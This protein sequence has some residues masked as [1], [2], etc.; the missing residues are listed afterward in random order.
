MESKAKFTWEIETTHPEKYKDLIEGLSGIT[1][2]ELGYSV[3]ELGLVREIKLNEEGAY[4]RMLLT[5]P[6]CPYG[7]AML[8][9]TRKKVEEILGG[10]TKIEFGVEQWTPD[11]MEDDLLDP[12]WGLLF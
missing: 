2:P 11:M 9:D 10:P 1:D 4:V 3:I 7:P 8:E 12:K 6:F 5:T